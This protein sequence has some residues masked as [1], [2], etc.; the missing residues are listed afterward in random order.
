MLFVVL[1]CVLYFLVGKILG[2]ILTE[3]IY[4]QQISVQNE[5]I[6]MQKKKIESL[7]L[8]ACEDWWKKGEEPPFFS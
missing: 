8:E 4:L 3:R 1:C 7:E 6:T 5:L 2:Q